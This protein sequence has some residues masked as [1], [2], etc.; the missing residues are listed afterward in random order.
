MQVNRGD[1]SDFLKNIITKKVADIQ[2]VFIDYNT[3]IKK[4]NIKNNIQVLYTPNTENKTFAMYY[5]FDMG[6]N[7]NK[8]L[9]IAINYLK[10]LGTKDLTA[11]QVQEEFY[12]LGCSYS[13]NAGEDQILI[14]IA[15]LTENIEKATKLL[16]NLL[17][18]AQPNE[19]AL[20]AL[21]W[22]YYRK[23]ELML[24]WIKKKSWKVL[25]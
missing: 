17:A 14:S 4:F 12:K 13:V 25:F 24:N 15:G 7:Q 19:E 2:P 10:Y 6:S 11:A 8:K 23:N 20:K 3:D 9:E 21:S 5:A 16:E 1:Q 18:N 22:R